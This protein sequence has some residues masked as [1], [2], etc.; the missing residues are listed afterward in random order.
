MKMKTNPKIIVMLKKPLKCDLLSYEQGL[1]LSR[2]DGPRLYYFC[3]SEGTIF[4]YFV[5]VMVDL[6]SVNINR[7]INIFVILW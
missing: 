3:L 6:N 1:K 7:M 2:M 4:G 5:S